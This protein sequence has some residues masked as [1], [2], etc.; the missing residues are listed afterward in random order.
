MIVASILHRRR[1]QRV[2]RAGGSIARPSNPVKSIDWDYRLMVRGRL[3]R[4]PSGI[5]R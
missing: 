5:E 2:K 1:A 3:S 4:Q